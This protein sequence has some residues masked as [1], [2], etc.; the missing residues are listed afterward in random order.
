MGSAIDERSVRLDDG[1]AVETREHGTVRFDPRRPD[2]DLNVLSHAHGDHLPSR[3]GAEPIICSGLTAQLATVR[4]EFG[5]LTPATHEAVELREAGHI[6]GSRSA[7]IDDR[8]VRLL[9]TGDIAT[10]DR[11][12]LAGFEPVS[13]DVLLIE[14][15]Y[16]SPEYV[17]PPLLT[18]ER[19]V[20]DW[21]SETRHR[22]AIWFG[23]ALGK[24][25]RLIRLFERTNRE[26]LFTTEAILRLNDV[27]ERS[28]RIG[29]DALPFERDRPLE[30]GD[31]L[32]LP[33]QVSRFDW[34]SELVAESNATT[35]GF[36][37]W[38]ADDGYVYRTP[39]DRGFVLSDH[40]DFA[41]LVEVVRE[42]EP[43]VVYTHHGHAGVLATEL[44]RLGY[45]ARSLRANQSTID[46]FR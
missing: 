22:P 20:N 21:L 16:G 13:A 8:D 3:V 4:R 46:D 19:T 9:Y 31:V 6:E 39:V 2:G 44:T 34:V 42:V 15:T 12:G 1:I 27:I 10:R 38:A 36:S 14:A 17:F 24:A 40:C 5:E 7:V 28:T 23:Y 11:Y 25:Q 35:A 30:P 18:V 37:G 29:F 33:S 43:E 45:T 41:E 26:R 32:I